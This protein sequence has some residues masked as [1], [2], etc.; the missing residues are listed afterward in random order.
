MTAAHAARME[1]LCTRP[2]N[3]KPNPRSSAAQFPIQL[4]TRATTTCVCDNYTSGPGG[5]S[6]RTRLSYVARD[7]NVFE[8]DHGF[9]ESGLHFFWE[10]RERVQN[11]I[12]RPLLLIEVPRRR[13]WRFCLHLA[14]HRRVGLVVGFTHITFL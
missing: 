6:L 14:A 11:L 5:R 10:R 13:R 12:D 2:A 1:N 9:D 4:R 7:V 3:E 8:D